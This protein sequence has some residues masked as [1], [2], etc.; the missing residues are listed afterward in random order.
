MGSNGPQHL[1]ILHQ[2]LNEMHPM[3]HFVY[4]QASA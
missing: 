2:Q 1:A 4:L 3:V